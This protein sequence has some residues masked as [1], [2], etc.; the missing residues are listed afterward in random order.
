MPSVQILPIPPENIK[1][2]R[3]IA[4]L[5]EK[6]TRLL[7]GLLVCSM[8][9][10]GQKLVASSMGLSIN[11]VRAGRAEFE[12]K[13][14]LED[15]AN[16]VRRVGAGR[17]T[18]EKTQPEVTEA[19]EQLL[20]NNSYGDP[21]R[22]LFWTTLS[23][24][25]MQK[26]LE[27]KGFK[28]SH[29]TISRLLDEMGY[30]K[31]LNQK[32]LQVGESHPNRDD[33]FRFIE[34]KVKEF[35]D[36]GDPVISVD[37]KKKELLGNFKN[38]GAEY[39]RKHD[40]RLVK[41]H[42]YIDKLLGKVAPYGIY[43]LNNNTGYVNLTTCSDA[44]EF[45]VESVRAWWNHIGSPTFP[46][47]KRLLIT[48][49]GGGSNG[50]RVRLWKEQLAVLSAELGLEITVCHFPPGTSKWNKVEHRLFC[51]ISRN[52]AGKPLTD[53]ETVVKL[54]SSTTTKTGLKVECR[55]DKKV[56]NKGIKVSDKQMKN[57][58]LTPLG[59]FGKWN[60][61]INGFVNPP[62]DIIK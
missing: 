12:E 16:R 50:C 53:I 60:Y 28:L 20:E 62:A 61:V 54:I 56:Y 46:N 35:L 38:N 55:E 17:K 27:S 19:L 13:K 52:W 10:G 4:E 58:N 34:A 42:D 8:G 33:Q 43:V 49:D 31:Q 57:I 15:A 41:D 14:G 22:V 36:R 25:G 2:F 24:R 23:L 5:T 39:R 6:Q 29:V 11:T 7:A 40:P 3:S 44:S 18:I 45:A 32:L 1:R 37:C 47:A 30:S 26:V 48:C 51:Y 21:E 59:E 9:H